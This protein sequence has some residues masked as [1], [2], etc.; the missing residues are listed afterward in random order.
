MKTKK[1]TSN[2]QYWINEI[3]NIF[4]GLFLTLRRRVLSDSTKVPIEDEEIDN[5]IPSR[6]KYAKEVANVIRKHHGK[7]DDSFIFGLSGKWGAGKTTVLKLLERELVK[8]TYEEKFIVLTISPW[9]Y[10]SEIVTFLRNFLRELNNKADQEQ[11]NNTLTIFEKIIRKRDNS[12]LTNLERDI[13]SPSIDIYSKK[14]IFLVIIVLTWILYKVLVAA[15]IIPWGVVVHLNS[16]QQLRV[17]IDAIFNLVAIMALPLIIFRLN[18]NTT[19]KQA[20]TLDQF[21]R[22][23]ARI[24]DK[25]HTGNIVVFVD[26]LDRVSPEV[27]RTV[28]DALRTF[29]DTRKVTFVVTGDHTVIEKHIG[30]QIDNTKDESEIVEEGRRYLKKMFNVYWPLPIPT[31][32]EFENF[33][34]QEL[35]KVKAEIEAIFAP[36]GEDADSNIFLLKKWLSAYFD[37]NFRNTIRFVESIIFYFGLVDTQLKTAD[38]A[39]KVQL[40]DVRNNPMLFI[41]MLIIQELSIPLYERYTETP[42]LM[43]EIE[44]DLISDKMHRLDQT[45]KELKEAK[46]LS[47]QQEKFLRK[48]MYE[49]PRFYEVGRGIVVHSIEPFIFLASS[50]DFSDVRGPTTEDFLEFISNQNIESI[51]AALRN[52]GEIKL[53]DML[54]KLFVMLDS[55]RSSDLPNLVKSIQTITE[56]LSQIEGTNLI[57]KRFL[58]QFLDLDLTSIIHHTQPLESRMSLVLAFSKWLDSLPIE[59]DF[60][61][62]YLKLA[63]K[64]QSEIDQIE[65]FI[66]AEP[67]IKE[68]SA[69]GYFSSLLICKWLVYQYQFDQDKALELLESIQDRITQD[70]LKEFLELK[71]S[72]ATEMAKQPESDKGEKIWSLVKKINDD[73]LNNLVGD[74]LSE[75]ISASRPNVTKWIAEKFD[76]V[77]AVTGREKI[78]NALLSIVKPYLNDHVNL[79][80]KISNNAL[81]VSQFASELWDEILTLDDVSLLA[82]LNL[83]KVSPGL[84]F[85]MPTTVQASTIA[86]RIISYSKQSEN[87]EKESEIL[88]ILKKTDL[89][90]SWSELPSLIIKRLKPMSRKN[91]KKL[92][93]KQ[94]VEQIFESWGVK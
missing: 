94:T 86:D 93:I 8:G 17:I 36:Y 41:R 25:F 38:D 83:I 19:S 34:E 30:S 81:L 61:Q 79:V 18:I 9:K 78:F 43:T 29:V 72:L 46:R 15:N 69:S 67:F 64:N 75:Q 14:T 27:A 49:H 57:Q 39:L 66:K 82:I 60:S 33:L 40:L 65:P 10:G 45:I 63:L 42:I 26:D 2:T 3:N 88:I 50:S 73:D 37:K 56:S 59:T 80:S 52:A 12:F 31:S 6:E 62:Y 87:E 54:D 71:E 23:Y 24:L 76:D 21:A 7:L 91:V 77:V 48:F 5:A 22:F 28:L 74:K 53:N 32:Q 35:T 20:A 58:D 4:S 16:N 70:S 90:N 84:N 89:W 55:Q 11:N 92:T 1:K 51:R 44:E 47:P 85:L 13:T 68:N